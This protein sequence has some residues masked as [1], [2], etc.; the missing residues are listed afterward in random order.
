MNT[1]ILYCQET[2]E[3]MVKLRAVCR[4]V[5]EVV[6]EPELKDLKQVYDHLSEYMVRRSMFAIIDPN[7]T[8]LA[9]DLAI[10]KFTLDEKGHRLTVETF[11]LRK[12]V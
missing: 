2:S 11:Q 6:G 3:S 9:A 4:D 10:K 8:V 5:Y 12:V 7:G 1:Y